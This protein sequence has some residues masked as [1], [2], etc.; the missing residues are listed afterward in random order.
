VEDNKEEIILT[1]VKAENQYMYL[2]NKKVFEDK[3][4]IVEELNTSKMQTMDISIQSWAETNISKK[5]H[6]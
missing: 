3:E 4:S 6:C 1:A 5:R 2:D